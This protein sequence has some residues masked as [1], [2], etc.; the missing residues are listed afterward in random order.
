LDVKVQLWKELK[1]EHLW[2]TKAA[3]SSAAET[4]WI[5]LPSRSLIFVVS[6]NEVYIIDG[7]LPTKAQLHR[8]GWTVIPSNLVASS[9]HSSGQCLSLT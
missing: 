8:V 9:L 4:R 7:P 3:L 1:Q 2:E 5:G 6:Q